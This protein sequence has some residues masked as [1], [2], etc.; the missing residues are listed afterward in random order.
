MQLWPVAKLAEHPAVNLLCRSELLL[1]EVRESQRVCNIVIP[2]R[3][4]QCRFKLR[5]G[6]GKL[7][8]D[9]PGLSQHVMCVSALRVAGEH[10]VERIKGFFTLPSIEVS[11]RQV[12][13]YFL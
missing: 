8:A 12:N 11:N 3:E 5:R 10:L 13:E 6:L 1:F 4:F 9:E 2:R 7:S